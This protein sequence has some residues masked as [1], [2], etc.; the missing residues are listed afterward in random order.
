MRGQ[1]HNTEQA[2][3]R[4]KMQKMSEKERASGRRRTA[5]SKTAAEK[6]IAEQ[7]EKIRE[8]EEKV[9]RL[10]QAIAEE[11]SE[12]SGQGTAASVLGQLGGMFPGLDRLIQ[13]L[14]KSEAFRDRLKAIDEEIEARLRSEP[15]KRVEEGDRSSSL[16]TRSSG[17][18][19]ARRSPPG[20]R[21]APIAEQEEI[22]SKEPPVDVF[23]EETHLKVVAELPGI[24]EEDIEIDLHGARL[25]ISANTPAH[26]CHREIVL[27][28]APQGKV[29]RL[30]RNGILELTLWKE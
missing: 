19:V 6:K 1:T 28:C 26:R 20:K 30:Y 21:P 15:L 10:E 5:E 27:P 8:L 17:R 14:E 18:T 9:R 12:G 25:V 7:E 23:D 4:G 24:E 11:E 2:E 13:G 22:V 3:G 29:E 16:Q